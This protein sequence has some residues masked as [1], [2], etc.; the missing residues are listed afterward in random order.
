MNQ[1]WPIPSI[2]L[3]ER[4]SPYSMG[5]PVGPQGAAPAPMM[6][7]Q[8]QPMPAPQMA[9]P[10]AP[11]AGLLPVPEQGG[12]LLSRAQNWMTPERGDLLMGLGMG[13]SQLAYNQPVDMSPAFEAMRKRRQGADLRK[14]MDAPGL[15][16]RFSPQQR[17][18]LAMMPE[19]L[20]L[21][22]ISKE[23]FRQPEVAAPMS[24]LGKLEADSRAGL[25][26]PEVY[27]AEM[28]RQVGGEGQH[29]LITGPEAAAMG[30]D[31]TSAYNMG[32]DGRVYQIGGGGTNVTV[33]NNAPNDDA[34]AR[35]LGETEAKTFSGFLE[36]APVAARTIGQLDQLQGMLEG[37]D[38]GFGAAS[39]VALGN[40]GVATQGLSE[41]QAAQALINQMVPA[42]RPPGSGPMS[43][44]DLELFKQSVPRLIN[45][46]GGNATIIDTMRAINEYDIA[47]GQIA[48]RAASGELSRADARAAVNA[49]ANPLEDFSS[50]VSGVRRPGTGGQ[51]GAAPAGAPQP[52]EVVDGY[53]Y[54][55]GDP[56]S[57]SSWERVE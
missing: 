23:A 28:A 4:P 2:L 25:I 8:P 16:D 35:T 3:G 15:M 11:Q 24:P 21:E 5:V 47:L 18:V 12:G 41:L 30:L 52:G 10:A 49:L 45:Q 51:Q 48:Q 55:G 40:F 7:Q 31:P 17:A 50:R 57:P 32:P 36:R 13:L 38:T 56:G 27:E 14:A 46:P 19:A 34:F 33:Q 54:R 43:D 9:A 20:A 53:R 39:R 44:A 26:S 42:Q 22:V 1:N 37:V 29:R 6:P